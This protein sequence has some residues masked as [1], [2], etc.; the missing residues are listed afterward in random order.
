MSLFK[1]AFMPPR[2]SAVISDVG[3]VLKSRTRFFASR[4]SNLRFLLER[5]Y[6]WM[7][8]FIGAEDAGIEVGSGAGFSREFIRNRNYELTDCADFEWLDRNVDATQLPYASESLDFVIESNMIHHLASPAAFL[9]EAHRVLKPGGVLLIQDVWGSLLLRLLCR[10]LKTEGYS[11]DVD[12]FDPRADCCDRDN[13]WA[14]NNVIPN[15]LFSDRDR[16]EREFGLRVE[17]LVHSEVLLF[18]M[19]GGVTSH[20]PVPTLPDAMLR[21]VERVDRVLA[22]VSPDVFAL[23]VRAV[24]RKVHAA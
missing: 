23:Q 11:Y 22:R 20:F 15:L 10:L 17:T 24:L 12:V 9:T 19:S 1:Q 2:P 13:A 4:R 18:P 21:L 14:G 7:N 16:V 8:D 6:G 3:D 5:R